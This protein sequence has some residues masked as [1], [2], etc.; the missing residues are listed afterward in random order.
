MKGGRVVSS[1]L[2]KRLREWQRELST[3][4]L[5]D[6]APLGTVSWIVAEPLRLPGELMTALD[7]MGGDIRRWLLA[8]SS[9]LKQRAVRRRVEGTLTEVERR[10][11]ARM[12]NATGFPMLVRPDLVV[13]ESGEPRIAEI[14]LQ[15]AHAGVLQKMQEIQ[16]VP[17]GQTIAGLWAGMFPGPVV[18]SVPQWKPYCSDQRYF[19][20]RV[21]ALGG[22]L[23][24]MPVEEW[25]R[26]SSFNGAVFK[27]CCTLEL[28][29]DDY[30]ALVPERAELYPELLLDW[31]GW[32]AMPGEIQGLGKMRLARSIP[33]SHLLPL[34]PA[35]HAER[36]RALV[37]ALLAEKKRWI[38]K[39]VGSWGGYGFADGRTLSRDRWNQILLGLSP[40]GPKTMLLQR[41]IESKRYAVPGLTPEGKVVELDKLRIR[42]GPYYV[43]TPE[44]SRLA[45][46]MVTLRQSTKVHT[47]T[48]AMHMMGIG[49][50]EG[51]D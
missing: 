32:L 29:K 44:E 3:V 11:V 22:A 27:N 35:L 24:F 2:E 49:E 4:Q 14:D 31:K 23:E 5:Y 16:G 6:T 39:P 42:L 13:D 10:A 46:V 37:D 19:A 9:L 38:I 26:L 7:R 17:A 18:L 50:K 33:E 30:P 36:R 21:R 34:H 15:P 40:G 48:D 47:Q 43:M 51:G 12:A 28:L 20:E 8:C 1:G 41:K 45:G 25:G